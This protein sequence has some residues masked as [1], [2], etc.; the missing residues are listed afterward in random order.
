MDTFSAILSCQCDD[1]IIAGNLKSEITETSSI[2]T[3][4][5]ITLDP[6][7]AKFS[8]AKTLEKELNDI[9]ANLKLHRLHRIMNILTGKLKI[10]GCLAVEK[11][12]P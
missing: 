6:T 12:P 1:F 11:T 8:T 7:E 2:E 5:N 4:D 9:Q 10:P 3:L